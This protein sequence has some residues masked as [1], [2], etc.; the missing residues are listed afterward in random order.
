MK[1]E[2]EFRKK[3]DKFLRTLPFCKSLSIQ[4]KAITGHPDKVLCLAGWF[5][6]LEIKTDEGSP[7]ARQILTLEEVI[8]AKGVALIVRPSNFD[9]IKEILVK[10]SKG[11]RYDQHEIQG[12][13]APKNPT[14]TR[15]SGKHAN[16]P[17]TKLRSEQTSSGSSLDNR[18][19]S[20]REHG[21]SEE[22]REI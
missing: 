2:S 16:G 5:V 18:E 20:C 4:Q 11:I 15:K 9:Q 13:N 8:K 22:F 10:I 19:D 7:S 1:A 21:D 12:I 3:V 14:S 6:G 17:K